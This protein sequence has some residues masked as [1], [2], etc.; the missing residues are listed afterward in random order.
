VE[1]LTIIVMWGL[2]AAA[3]AGLASTRGRSWFGYFLFSF[4]F[5]P[6]LGLIIVLVAKDLVEEEAKE[7][8]RQRDDAIRESDRKREHEEKLESLRAL[9]NPMGNYAASR[10][11]IAPLAA[12]LADELEK[13]AKLREKGILTTEEFETQK[14]A[15]LQRHSP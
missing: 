8:Q 13:L 14:R 2:L 3:V 10:A 9:A 5:S 12:S 4:L 15:L 1:L 6:I 7:T 11:S